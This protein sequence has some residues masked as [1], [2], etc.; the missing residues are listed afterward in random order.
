[1][2]M[3]PVILGLPSLG[4]QLRIGLDEF[5]RQFGL[6]RNVQLGAHHDSIGYGFCAGMVVKED[7]SALDILVFEDRFQSNNVRLQLFRFI[8]VIVSLV[9]VLMTPP[10]VKFASVKA[11]I[12]H[13]RAGSRDVLADGVLK[14]RLVDKC[15]NGAYGSQV[16]Q[17]VRP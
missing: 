14:F 12:Q 17:N 1:M 2:D 13:P 5:L 8:E 10:L 16:R 11:K 3:V 15:G 9:T 6:D 4:N 7:V